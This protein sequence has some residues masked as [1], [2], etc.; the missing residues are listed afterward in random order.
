MHRWDNWKRA[1]PGDWSELEINQPLQCA[2]LLKEELGELWQLDDGRRAWAFLRKGAKSHRQRASVK[3]RPSAKTLLRQAKGILSFYH[4]GSNRQMEDECDSLLVV[5]ALF[6]PISGSNN[7]AVCSPGD[8]AEQ[9][10]Q[11]TDSSGKSIRASNA[12]GPDDE[13]GG[14]L[15]PH[16]RPGLRRRS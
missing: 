2:Y 8:V 16:R 11:A 13:A 14:S 1:P 6:G 5:N 12:P 3:L 9:A 4:T 15:Q 10:K 7:R